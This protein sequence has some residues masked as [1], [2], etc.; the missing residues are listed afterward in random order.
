M[1]FEF[2]DVDMDAINAEVNRISQ[3]PQ[4]ATEFVANKYVK[5][6]KKDGFVLMR[7]MPAAKGKNLFCV[8]RTHRLNDRSWHC[9]RELTTN[10][11][12]QLAWQG[13]CVICQY[14]SNLW[15]RSE[16]K[17]LTDKQRETLQNKARQ[18]KPVERYYYNVIVRDH[19]EDKEHL[20]IPLIY[21]CG[22]TVHDK[23][24][25]AMTGDPKARLKSLGKVW[26]PT[27]GRD[28]L[29]VVKNV[30]S[31]NK[32]YPNYDSSKFEDPSVLG[33]DAQMVEWMA[34]AN[35]LESIRVVK[36]ADFLDHQLKLHLGLIKK[37][38]T[39]G[40]YDMSQYETDDIS[41]NKTN[42]GGVREELVN[43]PATQTTQNQPQSSSAPDDDEIMVDDEFMAGFDK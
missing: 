25:K 5:M 14:Y 10:A 40:K 39:G 42:E 11:R 17:S 12:G 35:D 18:I 37:E 8:S 34:N 2:E 29:L 27:E 26:H 30:R 16:D 22:K 7:I 36:D 21:S 43:K 28:F 13:D 9:P 24:L 20:N 3:E 41:F 31:G 1:S 33:T 32:E 6:P 38:A 4:N 23:I 19:S 15:K